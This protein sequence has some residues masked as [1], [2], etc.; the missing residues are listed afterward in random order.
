MLLQYKGLEWLPAHRLAL[1]PSS[2]RY[3]LRTRG[4][5]KRRRNIRLVILE[6]QLSLEAH[7]TLPRDKQAAPVASL[8]GGREV[9]V[10]EDADAL[11]GDGP[12]LLRP[13]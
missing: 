11:D 13:R 2:L 12:R 7:D 5:R 9:A 3:P 8:R 6:P 10:P 4:G 1:K